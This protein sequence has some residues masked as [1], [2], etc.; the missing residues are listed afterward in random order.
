MSSRRETIHVSLGSTANLVSAHVLNLQ[1]LAATSGYCP[2]DITHAVQ[3]DFYVPRCIFVDEGEALQFQ[4]PSIDPTT[5]PTNVDNPYLQAANVLAYSQHSRYLAPKIHVNKYS[6]YAT[7][8]NGRHVEWGNDEDAD[9]VE[10]DDEEQEEYRRKRQEREQY[11][12]QAETMP[13]LQK[14]L[15][16]HWATPAVPA[17]DDGTILEGEGS[18]APPVELQGTIAPLEYTSFFAPPFPNNYQCTLPFSSKSNMVET[19]DSYTTASVKLA[20]HWNENVLFEK[21]RKV[22]EKSDGVQGITIATEGHGIFAGLTTALLQE[23]HDECRTAGRIVM[24][25]TDPTSTSLAKLDAEDSWQPAHVLSVRQDVESGLALFDF[26]QTAHAIVPIQTQSP[27]ATLFERTS[28]IAMAWET[29]TLAYRAES[30]LLATGYG[31][32]PSRL[33][34]REF[35]TS[36]QPTERYKLL[37]LDYYAKSYLDLPLQPGTSVER[38][39]QQQNRESQSRRVPPGEWMETLL[40]ELSPTD[41]VDG[42]YS[43]RSLH[44]HWSLASSMR[45]STR[46]LDDL[47]C[48][49]EG[50]GIRY[51]P[52]SSLGVIVD[53]TFKSLVSGGYAAG[54]YWKMDPNQAVVAVLSNS[55]RAY[56]YAKKVANNMK[57]KLTLLKYKGYHNRDVTNG[58]LPEKED[59][60]EA[61]EYCLGLRDTYHPPEGS[62]LGDDEEGSY[63]DD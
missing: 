17:T 9:D 59:C 7:S 36:L 23:L 57:D 34:V 5:V 32:T 55:T 24:H 21:L 51:Q 15:E 19:W 16:D 14:L 44:H 41:N 4:D 10:D 45:S 37:E 35:L 2:A 28:Q 63:F 27:N 48:I 18:G 31:D 25:V 6:E 58:V 53:Q 26:G 20:S 1:G 8:S 60:L 47:T 12:W 11:Q 30:A 33:T 13:P 29:A 49:M 3:E 62:G 46:S 61:L 54:S 39:L 40:T 42:V 43:K 52:E 38:R 50:M 22:L 56:G